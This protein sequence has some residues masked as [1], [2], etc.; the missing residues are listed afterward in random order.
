MPELSIILP[1]LNEEDIITSVI[2]E[3]RVPLN[4]A[5]ID[6]ELILVDNGSTDR[7]LE[8]INALSKEDKRIKVVH[9]SHQ[10]WG[11]AIILGW[12]KAEGKY[13]SHMPS[14]GQ[15]DPGTLPVLLEAL[16]NNLADI[17]KVSRVTRENALRKYNSKSYNFLANLLFGV[18]TRDTNACP[19]MFEKKLL[20]KLALKS[21]DSFIDLE[22]MSKARYLNM[23]ILEI[24]A[25][26]LQRTG[27]KSNTSIKTVLEF[28]GNMFKFKLGEDFSEWKKA[29][30]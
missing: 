27:G 14:D 15:I 19:K 12:N 18:K 4:K 7:S 6:Y 16:R 30:G 5:K 20:N 2:K 28:V 3:I 8:V 21:L 29:N 11:R 13:V 23:R 25:F 24:S 26:G 9:T 22:L 10:G 1:V 17:V